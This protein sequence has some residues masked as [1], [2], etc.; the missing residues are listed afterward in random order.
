MLDELFGPDAITLARVQDKAT[1]EFQQWLKDRKNRRQIPYRFEQCGY[2]P[3]R[4]DAAADGLWSING[5][6]QVIYAKDSLSLHD[7]LAAAALLAR[8]H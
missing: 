8:W 7:R 3:V 2:V 6:R 1:G 5:R 4:N